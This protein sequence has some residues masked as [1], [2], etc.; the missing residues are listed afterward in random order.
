M[1][2]ACLEAYRATVGR[3]VVRAGPARL[4]LVP[5]LERSGAGTVLPEHRRLPRRAA[6]GPGQPEP[7]RRIDAGLPALAGGNAAHAKRRHRVQP[8]RF[9]AAPSH[10]NRHRPTQ[11]TS[12]CIRTARGCCSG[13]F[14]LRATSAPPESAPRSWPFPKAKSTRCWS[15]CRP[16][17]AT[18]TRRSDEFLQRRF[19]QVRPCLRADREALRRTAAAARRLFHATSIRSKPRRCSIP[20]SCRTRTSRTCRPARCVSS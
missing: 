4:R 5:R 11:P 20:P 12:S 1:V 14:I 15:R 8:A 13:R 18:A 10:E 19:E 17:S 2:S 6:R 3:L 9:V 16:N 7:G